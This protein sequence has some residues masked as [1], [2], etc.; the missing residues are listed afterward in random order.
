M[1]IAIEL[2]DFSQK[3]S[4]N[5]FLTYASEVDLS[6]NDIITVGK[7]LGS[8]GYWVRNER[9]WQ[10]CYRQK[11]SSSPRTPAQKI[12]N[13][14]LDEY[15]DAIK[16][17][18]ASW[19]KYAGANSVIK[20]GSSSLDA[21]F[22]NSINKNN[23]IGIEIYTKISDKLDEHKKAY[24]KAI[25]NLLF[26]SSKVS[27]EH[28]SKEAFELAEKLYKE[29]G[30]WDT[31]KGIG[32]A[33]KETAKNV[34]NAIGNKAREWN[35]SGAGQRI[36]SM[37]EKAHMTLMQEVNNFNNTLTTVKSEL[38]DFAKNSKSPEVQQ[39]ANNSLVSLQ[40]LKQLMNKQN[41]TVS[42]VVND[43]KN[44]MSGA[45]TKQPVN[46]VN[47]Q[48]QNTAIVAP[49]AN[50]NSTVQ[51]PTNKVVN[52][53]AASPKL[54]EALSRA[55]E[56]QKDQIIKLVQ[57]RAKAASAKVLTKIAQS[58]T[59]DDELFGP[60]NPA[61]AE[62][63]V[64]DKKI[65]PTRI[66]KRFT[67]KDEQE[68]AAAAG[69]SIP[70]RVPVRKNTKAPVEKTP[71]VEVKPGKEEVDK[72]ETLPTVGNNDT[73][74][75]PAVNQNAVS[76]SKETGA[77]PLA[78]MPNSNGAIPLENADPKSTVQRPGLNKV[79]SPNVQKPTQNVAPA[80][81][82]LPLQPININIDKNNFTQSLMENLQRL[83]VSVRNEIEKSIIDTVLGGNAAPTPQ[84]PLDP[85]AIGNYASGSKLN[86]IFKLT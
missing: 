76:P 1:N 71:E 68:S 75:A 78:D 11:R 46:T 48:Q 47:Q 85:S 15:Q 17:D 43:I 32:N 10:G 63:P 5:G 57:E 24:A 51:Q 20:V 55:T 49:N 33:A 31:I 26:I 23:D 2:L 60:E 6:A 61:S 72:M 3:L 12:W 21:Q 86:R 25:E 56:D 53:P 74:A 62:T 27:D 9:C 82:A 79:V 37:L 28:I 83:P 36:S 38:T 14:C 16:G 39:R 4:A 58:K 81:E 84:R 7:E 69:G 34:G 8:Q 45:A 67:K 44:L 54:Q 50:Q 52:Q 59:L 19:D 64:E 18:N 73:H 41:G 35:A 40:S 77:I 22:V 42:Q 30:I 13:Q 29:A 65:T 80:N 66:P 70:P